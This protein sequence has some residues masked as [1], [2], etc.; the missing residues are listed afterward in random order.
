MSGADELGA[1]TALIAAELRAAA[2]PG[3]QRVAASFA[4]TVVAESAVLTIDDDRHPVPAVIRVHRRVGALA[5]WGVSSA[6]R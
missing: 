6:G 3:W 1:L 2:A 4:M 5:G